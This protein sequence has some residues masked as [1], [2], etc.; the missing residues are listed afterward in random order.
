[1]SAVRSKLAT[2]G[3]G[4]LLKEGDSAGKGP[5]ITREPPSSRPLRDVLASI[6]ADD[7]FS[8]RRSQ[9][10]ARHIDE[11]RKALEAGA[12]DVALEASECA[13]LLSPDDAEAVACMERARAGLEDRE[14]RQL[15]AD[16]SNQIARGAL[17]EASV[18]IDRALIMVPASREA[19]MLR[20]TLNEARERVAREQ[21]HM[22]AARAALSAAREA[23]AHGGLEAALRHVLEADALGETSLDAAS[24][25]SEIEGAIEARRHAESERRRVKVR[26]TEA[27]RSAREQFAS[28][29]YAAAFELLDE[30]LSDP[31]VQ[32]VHGELHVKLQEIALE[33]RRAA[34]AAELERHRA[35][36]VAEL[37]SRRAAEAEALAQRRAAEEE[38]RHQAEEAYEQRQRA[39]R[40]ESER[41]R[42]REREPAALP[43]PSDQPGPVAKGTGLSS[44][45][46]KPPRAPAPV[47]DAKAERHLRRCRLGC[48][49]RD[50]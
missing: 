10:L 30:F 11:A 37:E 1:M 44:A 49:H 28:G 50:P 36:E 32:A 41:R 46:S 26:V 4:V 38:R 18:I 27:V 31:D 35:A 20:A 39:Q 8:R 16:A 25:K 45:P 15:L 9:Q 42:L 43:T 2:I 17:A 7:R 14:V 48:P 19:A 34:E 5:D 6:P 12:F 22:G 33:E 29:R 13:L 24:L 3:S 47:V 23:L 21:E 40:A